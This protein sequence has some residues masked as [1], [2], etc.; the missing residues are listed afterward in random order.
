MP[1]SVSKI[2]SQFYFTK[3]NQLKLKLL[4]HM[5]DNNYS[6]PAY[7]FTHDTLLSASHS[8]QG[9]TRYTSTRHKYYSP[10]DFHWKI[11]VFSSRAFFHDDTRKTRN[12][13][14]VIFGIP[15]ASFAD[16][17]KYLNYRNSSLIISPRINPFP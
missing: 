14:S 13:I 2:T 12:P 1:F 8:P 11:R 10:P 6:P 3:I 16:K 4:I 17:S 7:S 5:S 15:Q 9:K